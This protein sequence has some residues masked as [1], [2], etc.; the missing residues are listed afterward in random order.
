MK[1]NLKIYK[2]GTTNVAS[3]GNLDILCFPILDTKSTSSPG[4][5][6]IKNLTTNTVTGDIEIFKGPVVEKV[7]GGTSNVTITEHLNPTTEAEDGQIDINVKNVYS[8]FTDDQEGWL[9]W[10]SIEVDPI[11]GENKILRGP[12]LEF[13]FPKYT[14][15]GVQN[16]FLSNHTGGPG[17]DYTGRLDIAIR[18]EID[19]STYTNESGYIVVK[20]VETNTEG[21][22]V[23]KRGPIV[24]EVNP[25]GHV[26]IYEKGTTTQANQGL[27]DIKP[28]NLYRVRF[29]HTGE[30]GP[31]STVSAF[32]SDGYLE[33]ERIFMD[34][35]IVKST[36][37]INT[38]VNTGSITCNITRVPIVGG[39]SNFNNKLDLI[40]DITSEPI[41]TQSSKYDIDDTD[42]QCYAGDRIYTTLTSSPTFVG[43]TG[44]GIDD[45]YTFEIVLYI[46]PLNF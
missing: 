7:F 22:I 6:V 41:F 33:E 19:S 28:L 37:R 25:G 14:D 35:A 9:V 12:V 17:L 38:S 3:A 30:I 29:L 40:L 42:I 36:F 16:I 1:S 34:S 2:E 44:P 11:T 5:E 15:P 18:Q 8:I 45:I 13:L 21:N 27:L 24:E 43:T 23:L 20:D 39:S 4:K 46:I 10:K 26:R 31:S 32:L